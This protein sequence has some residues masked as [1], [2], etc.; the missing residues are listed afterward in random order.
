[1]LSKLL[2]P[3][4]TVAAVANNVVNEKSGQKKLLDLLLI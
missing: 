1:M 2:G 3:L 4:G